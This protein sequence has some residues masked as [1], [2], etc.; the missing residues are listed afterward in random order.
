MSL[1]HYFPDS[2]RHA[3]VSIAM[4]HR[5][6]R[7]PDGTSQAFVQN[8]RSRTY[9]YRGMAIRA[10]NEEISAKTSGATTGLIASTITL[11]AADLQ[12][13]SAADWRFHFDGAV[14]MMKLYG[15]MGTVY[16][17]VPY[18]KLVLVALIIMEGFGNTTSPRW[19]QSSA[20]T[21]LGLSDL[22]WD[23]YGDGV[24][25]LYLGTL[26]PRPLLM[27]VLTI[28]YLRQV[29]ADRTTAT[30]PVSL[31]EDIDSFS[32]AEWV[33]GKATPDT[34][35]Q[36]L[37][38]GCL[39]QSA[40]ALYCTMSLQ[41]VGLLD[42]K[43]TPRTAALDRAHYERL[44]QLLKQVFAFPHLRHCAMWPLVVAGI[45][46]ARGSREDRRYV[47]EEL[48]KGA[49]YGGSALPLQAKGLLERFWASGSMDWEDCFDR[50]YVFAA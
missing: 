33:E 11:L 19:N 37:L 23:I 29:D 27:N 8:A 28:N 21:E 14:A 44:L 39:Y 3:F 26:C 34:R 36:W 30:D 42:P 47:V 49:R 1:I 41:S 4:A 43:A 38:L 32:P 40:V 12:L 13:S 31:L 18:M 25:P 35:P 7:L 24:L 15:G 48:K 5:L 6:Y 45:R 20:V 2:Q 10:L 9:Q 17:T 16:R 22:V 50:P 46:A